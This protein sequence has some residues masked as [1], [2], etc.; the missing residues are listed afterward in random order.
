[1][2]K[3]CNDA[4]LISD[5]LDRQFVL[6]Y[7][8]WRELTET[9]TFDTYQYKSINIINGIAEVIHNISAYLDGITKTDHLIYSS[10][11]ELNGLVGRDAVLRTY[12][13]SI[14]R[15]IQASINKKL[16]TTGKLK[17]LRYQLQTYQ[18]FLVEDYDKK[19]AELLAEHICTSAADIMLLT[20]QYISRCVDLGWSEKALHSKIEGLKL[21]SEFD[22]ATT[23]KSLLDKLI[24]APKQSFSVFFPY[25]IKVTSFG[26]KSKEDSAEYV[27]TKLGEL[28]I[29]VLSKAQISSDFAAVDI[30]KLK[31]DKYLV[32]TVASYD[33]FSASHLAVRE[34]SRA[35]SILSFF[36]A[37]ESGALSTDQWIVFNN[38]A[39]HIST[40]RLNQLYGTYEY[41]DSSSTVFS[42][43]LALIRES[44][45]DRNDVVQKIQS[46]LSFASLS[47]ASTSLEEKYMNM[48]IAL[49]SLCLTDSFDNIIGSILKIVPDAVSLRYLYRVVRNFVE[50]CNRCE[51]SFDFSTVTI[52]SR[53]PNKEEV[54]CSMMKLLRDP[55]G[56]AELKDHCLV[57][58]LLS[59]R[60]EDIRSIVCDHIKL[61][62]TVNKH[63]ETVSWHLDRLYR[64]RNEIAHAAT[65]QNISTIRYIEHLYDYLATLVS[66]TARFSREY[67]VAYIGE[68]FSLISDN[69][70]EFKE[71]AFAQK[72]TDPPAQLGKLWSHGV[73]EFV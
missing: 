10:C 13:P 61:R 63:H 70:N 39:P 60:C 35:L 72:I 34:V 32:K 66:E 44:N 48:L 19:L 18:T 14:Q 31:V 38:D 21:P 26:G 22:A 59:K 49:E 54:V 29:Q 71:I 58:T 73:I 3:E 23:V 17:A 52:N 40:I 8:V 67:H 46:S 53:D 7:Q 16:D 5:G 43:V 51:I 30:S 28:G 47:R 55:I 24:N 33:A 56:Y 65:P 20:E 42:R 50:D 4:I 12:Y 37:I 62:E 25:R 15:R 57:N 9:K 69:Y 41:L 11:A 2:L 64:I 45:N 36:N 68:V 6:C 1:M 27:A